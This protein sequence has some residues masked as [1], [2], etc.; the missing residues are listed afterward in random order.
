M[1]VAHRVLNK[2]Y[3]IDC[4][5][6]EIRTIGQLKSYLLNYLEGVMYNNIK[7]LG[8]VGELNNEIVITSDM[9]YVALVI[10]PVICTDHVIKEQVASGN[11]TN[12]K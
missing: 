9:T 2:E 12:E 5:K 3:D 6:Y 11:T 4:E 7:I 1:I 10:I 8:C